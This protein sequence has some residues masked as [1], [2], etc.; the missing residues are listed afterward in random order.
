MAIGPPK[1]K[2]TKAVGNAYKIWVIRTKAYYF[3]WAVAAAGAVGFV[4]G[5]VTS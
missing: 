3:W 4:A 2:P 5:R 1:F